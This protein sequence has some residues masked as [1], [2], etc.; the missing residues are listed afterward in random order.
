MTQKPII[1]QVPALLAPIEAIYDTLLHFGPDNGDTV[2]K[3]FEPVSKPWKEDHLVWLSPQLETKV[4]CLHA[5]YAAT[6]PAQS[7]FV[8]LLGVHGLYCL[9]AHLMQVEHPALKSFTGVVHAFAGSMPAQKTVLN[10][11]RGVAFDSHDFTTPVLFLEHGRPRSIYTMWHS[12]GTE[13]NS[14]IAFCG[15]AAMELKEQKHAA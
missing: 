6:L 4:D 15:S 9:A 10:H 14:L 1:I 11:E 5:L 3:F 12:E 2:A 8:K 7:T 13:D